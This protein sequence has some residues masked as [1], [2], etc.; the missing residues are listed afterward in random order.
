L[1]CLQLVGLI[2]GCWCIDE[3]ETFIRVK[4]SN[5]IVIVSCLF[6]LVGYPR[7]ASTNQS[8]HVINR[9]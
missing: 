5:G 4:S 6:E 1:N 7:A 9:W 3:V 8:I 2:E